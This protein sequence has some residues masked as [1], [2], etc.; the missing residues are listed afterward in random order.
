MNSEKFWF[1]TKRFNRKWVSASDISH[2]PGWNNLLWPRIQ[3]YG[4]IFVRNST[5]RKISYWKLFWM[6]QTLHFSWIKIRWNRKKY[7]LDRG[8]ALL[9]QTWKGLECFTKCNWCSPLAIGCR[10][11]SRNYTCCSTI[12]G[13]YWKIYYSF[14]LY[15]YHSTQI[16]RGTFLVLLIIQELKIWHNL[17]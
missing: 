8:H 3:K 5:D 1:E 15:S 17:R 14:H 6:H 12:E 7:F 4:K 16:W 10:Y 2:L 9:H 13:Y 11:W